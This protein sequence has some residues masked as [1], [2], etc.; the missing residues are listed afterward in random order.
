MLDAICLLLLC[1]YSRA[2]MVVAT[3]GDSFA[4]ALYLAMKVRP[5]LLKAVA[6][7][8]QGSISFVEL[9]RDFRAGR[10]GM[11]VEVGMEYAFLLHCP[12]SG[13]L[14]QLAG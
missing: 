4:D 6:P 11:I 2:G 7:P 13:I 5:D 12:S 8:D 9:M 14:R 10:V 1:V 3:V